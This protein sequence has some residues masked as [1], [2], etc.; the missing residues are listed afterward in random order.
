M[1]KADFSLEMPLLPEMIPVLQASVENAAAVFGMDRKDALALTLAVEEVYCYMCSH[2]DNID[3]VR[4]ECQNGLYY[5]QVDFI[6]NDRNLNLGAFNLCTRISQDDEKQLEEMGLLIAARSVDR[7]YLADDTGSAVR[8]SLYKEKTYP[9]V[10]EK[11]ALDERERTKFALLPV[12]AEGLKSLAELTP[13]LDS[14][15]FIPSF[16][17]YPGKLVDMVKSGEYRAALAGD[18]K[19]EVIG[20]I[21][22]RESNQKTVELYGPYIF[23]EI[24]GM[25]EALIEYFL[26]QIGRSDAVGVLS[27][28]PSPWLSKEYFELLGKINIHTA[29]VNKREADAY[30]RQLGEDLGMK[31]W[32]HPELT[33]YLQS[34]Y[35][36]LFLPRDIKDVR[37]MGEQINPHSVFTSDFGNNQV[38]LR[39]LMDGRDAAENLSRH[40]Q[41]FAHEKIYNIFLEMDLAQAWQSRLAPPL[42]AN[43]F[44]PCLIL[45]YAGRGDLLLWQYEAGE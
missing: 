23:A 21:V 5:V 30:Y 20:G 27:R 39:P 11:A 9:A 7:L 22:W 29:E 6:F 43:R 36:R 13:G 2:G 1:K 28:Y 16:L 14:A 41:L 24:P 15:L 19:Q 25:A 31:V 44:K 26:E 18:D 45:P 37:N 33:A 40:L 4:L 12:E 8:L 3:K 17:L 34:Q 38:T 42:L 10:R 32:T 35:Q